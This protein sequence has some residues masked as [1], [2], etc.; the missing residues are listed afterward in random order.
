LPIE[1]S[2][3]TIAAAE[4]AYWTDFAKTGDPNGGGRPKW[5]ACTAAS[6]EL[7]DFT[8]AGAVAKP[9]LWKARLDLIEKPAA[10][11]RAGR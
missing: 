6:D 2:S 8:F 11:P 5:P 7:L 3:R 9:D 10:A 1:K 4:K